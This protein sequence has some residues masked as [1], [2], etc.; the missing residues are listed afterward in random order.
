MLNI[1]YGS[2]TA[3]K[4]KFIFEHIKGRTLL[5]VPDQ[6]SLQAEKDAFFYLGEKSLMDLIVVDF[7]SLGNKAV[8]ESGGRKPA[9]I[10]KYGRH[11]LL[12]RIID[13]IEDE[14][15]VFRGFSWKN[16]FADMMNSMI[17]EMK[18]YDITPEDIAEA[19]AGLDEGSY[20]KYKLHDIEKI[21]MSYQKRIE[22]KYLDSEDYITF[23]GEK[24]FHIACYGDSLTRGAGGNGTTYVNALASKLK[25]KGNVTNLGVGG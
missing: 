6:F 20:L 21:F 22:G 4:S 24:V 8:T 3:D 14:L 18:R 10:D 1:Y 25:R 2:E 11:I 16:S 5:L 17:S 13:E 19:E 9:M 12:T 15:K 23:Y 7:S